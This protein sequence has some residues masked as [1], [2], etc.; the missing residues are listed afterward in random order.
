MVFFLFS[1]LFSLRA[2]FLALPYPYD[3]VYCLNSLQSNLNP[4]DCTSVFE[5][6]CKRTAVPNTQEDNIIYNTG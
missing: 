4:G 3:G 5:E 1:S 6:G 2:I